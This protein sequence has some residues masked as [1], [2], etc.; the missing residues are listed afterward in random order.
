VDAKEIATNVAGGAAAIAIVGLVG[1]VFIFGREATAWSVANTLPEQV[2]APV[3]EFLVGIASPVG[4]VEGWTGWR[5]GGTADLSDL[6]SCLRKDGQGLHAGSADG[7]HRCV[8]R[9]E[10]YITVANSDT[11]DAKLS[12]SACKVYGKFDVSKYVPTHLRLLIKDKDRK[13][14]RFADAYLNDL[15]DGDGRRSLAFALANK[16]CEFAKRIVG[17]DDLEWRHL[18]FWGFRNDE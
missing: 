5:F 10:K 17:E 2:S 16:D 9:E 7:S 1:S 8:K 14:Q 11:E 13:K 18:A 3:G 6:K 15:P 4:W 12:R